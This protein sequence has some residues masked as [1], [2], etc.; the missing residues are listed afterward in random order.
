MN[1]YPPLFHDVTNQPKNAT[2][3]GALF[4]QIFFQRK[5]GPSHLKG[6]V[7]GRKIW[8][9]RSVVWKEAFTCN[10]FLGLQNHLKEALR[11]LASRAP[12]QLLTTSGAQILPQPQI[13]FCQKGVLAA[14]FF[15]F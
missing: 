7:H 6:R 3:E 11:L 2:L 13:W 14:L 1:L 15:L 8:P 9:Q 12:I 10:G 4:L 5:G